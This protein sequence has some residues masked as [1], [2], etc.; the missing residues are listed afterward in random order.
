MSSI[1]DND[2]FNKLKKQLLNFDPV[3]FAQ[4]YL[5]LDGKPF[6]LEGNGYRP[7]ADIYRYIGVKAL[8]PNAKP[9]IITKGRQVGATTM[10]SVLEMYFMGSGIFGVGDKPPIRII[11]AFPHLELAAAYSKTKLNQMIVS[12]V[13]VPDPEKKISKSKSY[14]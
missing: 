4:N 3:F 8:E 13:S 10:A 5:T 11:H 2:L 14:M 6:R 9:V 7:F 1:H 12:S